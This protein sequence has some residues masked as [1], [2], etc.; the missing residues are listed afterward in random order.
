MNNVFFVEDHDEVLKI[1]RNKNIK[2]LDLVHID[3]HMDFEF[4]PARPIEKIIKTARTLEEFKKSLEYSLCFSHYEKD[5]D[6]QT[7][8]GNYIYSAMEEGI[9]KDFYW[10]IPGG[11]EEFKESAKIIKNILR[12]FSKQDSSNFSSKSMQKVVSQKIE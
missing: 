5:F 10:V 2:G 8:I 3:A 1:W 4:H 7:N 6:K 12:R 11:L 9:V